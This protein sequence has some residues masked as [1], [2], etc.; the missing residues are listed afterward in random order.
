MSV[1]FG[2]KN[3]NL[4]EPG[5]SFYLLYFSDK[6]DN[7][8][9]NKMEVIKPFPCDICGQTFSQKGLLTSH[10][11]IHTSEKLYDCDN[12]EKTFT[13]KDRLTSHKRIH[14]GERPYVC[15]TCE[16]TFTRKDK[17]THHKMFHTG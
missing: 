10:F 2:Y 14:T 15:D 7:S 3:N 17:L 6:E 5:E 13:R 1:I 11:R 8:F 4:F 9:S 12:C 16:K